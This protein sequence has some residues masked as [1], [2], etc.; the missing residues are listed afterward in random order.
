MG[1]QHLNDILNH[2]LTGG[3]QGQV[4]TSCSLLG[5]NGFMAVNSEQHRYCLF[6]F[7]LPPL[8]ICVD[9]DWWR[10]FKKGGEEGGGGEE[11]FNC[12]VSN[13]CKS[14]AHTAI[15]L[16]KRNV[17]PHILGRGFSF[18]KCLFFLKEVGCKQCFHDIP[19]HHRGGTSHL[20]QP[21]K[22]M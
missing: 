9:F 8:F 2:G 20:N 5:Y 4:F 22:S 17:N 10:H 19:N 1:H 13:S 18:Y 14:T 21:R 16:L 11:Y 15:V 7:Y 12:L 3:G 6:T